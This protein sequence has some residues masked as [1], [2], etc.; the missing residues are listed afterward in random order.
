MTTV[1]TLVKRFTLWK[2]QKGATV[3]ELEQFQAS[4]SLPG[5][6]KMVVLLRAFTWASAFLVCIWTFYYLGSQAVS[7]EYTFQSMGTQSRT[8]FELA[9]LSSGAPSS[10]TPIG[11]LSPVNTSRINV[12][13]SAALTEAG[14]L[15]QDRRFSA[16]IPMFNRTETTQFGKTEPPRTAD[17]GHS[18]IGDKQDASTH[19]SSTIGME[20][21]S[22]LQFV[23]DVKMNTSYIFANCADPIVGT[24][25]AFPSGML[26]TLDTAFNVTG[27]NNEGFPQVE[28]WKRNDKFNTTIHSLCTLETRPIF[29]NVH[30]DTKA[31]SVVRYRPTLENS[32]P[33]PAKPFVD[34]EF[35]R[36]F[37]KNLMLSDGI[38]ASQNEETAWESISSVTCDGDHAWKDENKSTVTADLA[39]GLSYDLT[40]LTNTYLRASQREGQQVHDPNTDRSG[41]VKSPIDGNTWST[42]TVYGAFYNP[43]YVLSKPWLVVDF[44]TCVI[45]FFAAIA[46]CWLRTRTAAPDIF[47]CKFHKERFTSRTVL[48]TWQTYHP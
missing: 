17:V 46:S 37:Y 33:T 28:I 34:T 10:F 35:S 9:F 15:G 6:L 48:T 26:P 44:F 47:G 32:L 7:R 25:E 21:F 43:Q 36:V 38:P 13:F 40:R 11:Q 16:M 18:L 42:A 20:L 1:A 24:S 3:A 27:L 29:L 30:C 22:P 23:G 12:E 45:L 14:P 19:Y 39:W 5:T 31:C 41:R 2:A 8:N 4:I